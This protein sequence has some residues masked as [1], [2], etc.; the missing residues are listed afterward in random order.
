[1]LIPS[2][3]TPFFIVRVA[4]PIFKTHSNVVGKM[5]YVS[6]KDAECSK[7][8]PVLHDEGIALITGPKIWGP[9]VRRAMKLKH[10]SSNPD[11][12][13]FKRQLETLRR[14]RAAVD[15][16]ML[17]TAMMVVLK[18]YFHFKNRG[19]MGP[20]D[21]TIRGV[22]DLDRFQY[23]AENHRK[24]F[25]YSDEPM[26]SAVTKDPELKQLYEEFKDYMEDGAWE[27]RHNAESYF[28]QVMSRSEAWLKRTSHIVNF[29]AYFEKQ[30]QH[31][32]QSSSTRTGNVLLK[33]ACKAQGMFIGAN[34]L[35]DTKWH[36][37][38]VST[39]MNKAIARG[40]VGASAVAYIV[41]CM[42]QT[43]NINQSEY[44]RMCW[45]YADGRDRDDAQ[46]K[47]FKQ[48]VSGKDLFANRSAEGYIPDADE[49]IMLFRGTLLHTSLIKSM[50]DSGVLVCDRITSFTTH[51]SI[52]KNFMTEHPS[53][54]NDSI[55]S[56]NVM[57]CMCVK[58]PLSDKNSVH[59]VAKDNF[60]RFLG[61]SEHEMICLPGTAL[62]VYK[63]F[64]NKMP[65]LELDGLARKK[66]ENAQ[67]D[68]KHSLKWIKA[69][70]E[71][72]APLN[73]ATSS[74]KINP[75]DIADHVMFIFFTPIPL[76]TAMQACAFKDLPLTIMK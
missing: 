65:E 61:T 23:G 62:K 3:L 38:Y 58:Y 34:S 16:N 64:Y 41:Y 73:K 18:E 52:W 71:E 43:G 30:G 53:M 56:K 42:F 39:V 40:S 72:L 66:W 25:H 29:Q 2:Q 60:V 27:E 5:A 54:V 59:Q 17:N 44:D 28:D 69:L 32:L 57:T 31:A 35:N 68:E 75:Q 47:V 21:P 11:R 33:I 12:R 55:P 49:T 67:G 1:M 46:V 51:L 37:E 13:P 4:Q 6:R 15:E 9:N 36:T 63:I 45:Q 26:K 7:L 74:H 24:T 10:H 8:L 48:T 22:S 14:T 70:Q 20:F 50:R 19:D 76:H